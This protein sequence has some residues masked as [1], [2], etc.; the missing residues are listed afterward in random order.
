MAITNDEIND[1]HLLIIDYCKAFLVLYGAEHCTPNMYVVCHLKERLLDYG[2]LAAFWA[3]SFEHY[4]GTL[5]GIQMSWNGPEKQ[6]LKK[7]ISLQNF[8]SVERLGDDGQNAFLNILL[9]ENVLKVTANKTSTSIGQSLVDELSL[10]QRSVYFTCPVRSV[11]G[12]LKTYFSLSQPKYER[13]FL[14]TENYVTLR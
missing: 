9:K 8:T 6:M 2:P 7:F 13:C 10:L 5:E 11:D 14:A 3:F 1:A 4:N 12:N